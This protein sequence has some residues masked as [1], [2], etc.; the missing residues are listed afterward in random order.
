MLA[1]R[2]QNSVQLKSILW[3]HYGHDLFLWLWAGQ[4]LGP[5]SFMVVYCGPILLEKFR[6]LNT[7]KHFFFDEINTIKHCFGKIGSCIRREHRELL[8]AGFVLNVN[9]FPVRS[10]LGILF[11]KLDACRVRK[12]PH[13]ASF[14]SFF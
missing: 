13:R 10:F 5:A 4:A 8:R 11:I 2:Y 14:L 9:T 6:N 7:I 3:Y 12:P 1:I